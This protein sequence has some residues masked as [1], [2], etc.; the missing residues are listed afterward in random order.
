MSVRAGEESF[1]VNH[2]RKVREATTVARTGESD[3]ASDIS[4]RMSG[5]SATFSINE[6]KESAYSN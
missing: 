3:V 6:K 4:N 5:D 2:P 1:D